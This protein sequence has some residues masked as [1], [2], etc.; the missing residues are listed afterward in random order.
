MGFQSA[1]DAMRTKLRDAI[2]ASA[3]AGTPVQYDNGPLEHPDAS[4]WL[5]HELG[6][7][8]GQGVELGSGASH[9]RGG[10]ATTEVY[11]PVE[12]GDKQA[13]ELADVVASAFRLA[14]V[15]GVLFGAPSLR[16][17]GRI[18]GLGAGSDWWRVDVLCPYRVDLAAALAGDGPGSVTSWQAV[19]NAA[20]SRFKTKIADPEALP[21]QY[22]NAPLDPPNDASWAHVAVLPGE[23]ALVARGAVRRYRAPG[24]MV[25]VLSIPV[26]AGDKEALVLADK[27]DAAF[28]AVADAGVVYRTPWLR[29]VGR[30][31]AWWQAAVNVPFYADLLS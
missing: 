11:V 16:R 15:D 4:P 26:E 8:W 21:T 17:V 12:E 31:E 20:R 5:R 28:R 19:H 7:G 29:A 14:K 1:S 18:A 25:V 6:W 13:L 27:V 23:G 2:A 30:V 10:A 9:R 24:V 22:D 3:F